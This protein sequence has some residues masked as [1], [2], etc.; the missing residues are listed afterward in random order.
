MFSCHEPLA[1][2]FKLTLSTSLFKSAGDMKCSGKMDSKQP[3]GAT[4]V[5]FYFVVNFR[6]RRSIER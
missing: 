4:V 2:Y 5:R 6:D 1:G 3:S